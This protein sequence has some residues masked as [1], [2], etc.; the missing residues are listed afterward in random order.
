ML[1]LIKISS[2][3]IFSAPKYYIQFM[4]ITNNNASTEMPFYVAIYTVIKK[5]QWQFE[6]FEY[7]FK[8]KTL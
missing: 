7:V 8:A 4:L 5:Y 2:N 1:F 6:H 3:S